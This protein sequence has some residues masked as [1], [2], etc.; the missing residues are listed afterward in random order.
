VSKIIARRL[1]AS[2]HSATPTMSVS[3]RESRLSVV[4]Q[5]AAIERDGVRNA[6]RS[7]WQLTRDH[8]SHIFGL[9]LAFAILTLGVVLGTR[10]LDTGSSTSAG[11]VALGIAVNTTI[12]SFTALATAL[13]YFDLLARL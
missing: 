5:A 13:L 8:G 7:S 3:W 1:K 6:L 12:A 11:N 9:L 4:P 2:A 10:A